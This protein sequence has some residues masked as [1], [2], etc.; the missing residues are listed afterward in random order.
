[1]GSTAL[2][3]ASSRGHTEIVRILLD[4][5]A[6]ANVIVDVP[7]GVSKF[8][9]ENRALHAASF[10]GHTEIIRILLDH[11]AEIHALDSRGRNALHVASARGKIEAVQL[12]LD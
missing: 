2:H 5:G 10:E 1:H 9:I 6:A 11:G 4:Y 7:R 12:L 3:D 8:V